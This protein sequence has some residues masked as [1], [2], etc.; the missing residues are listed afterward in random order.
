VGGT[1]GS[2]QEG[3]VIIRTHTNDLNAGI[4][5]VCSYSS[6]V[7]ATPPRSQLPSLVSG[8]SSSVSATHNHL[9]GSLNSID[10]WCGV[11]FIYADDRRI[12]YCF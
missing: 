11:I 6:S 12:S 7:S 5:M 3:D 1:E 4:S 8:Y 2:S 10:I 9:L